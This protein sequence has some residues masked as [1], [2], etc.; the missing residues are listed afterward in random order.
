MTYP[1]RQLHNVGPGDL[2]QRVELPFGHPEEPPS[3]LGATPSLLGLGA[4]EP[5]RDL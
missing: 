1:A 5:R 4:F 3:H 2:P